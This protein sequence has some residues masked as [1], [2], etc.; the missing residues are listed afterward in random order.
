MTNPTEKLRKKIR[1]QIAV[2]TSDTCPHCREVINQEIFEPL[3]QGIL[4]ACKE[5]VEI[6]GI[7]YRLKFVPDEWKRT[8]YWETFADALDDVNSQIEE[9][10]L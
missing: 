1:Y 8:C 3:E 2:S 9:L 4:Q 7:T 5:G 10:E 6:E